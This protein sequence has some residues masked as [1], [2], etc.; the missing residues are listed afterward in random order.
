MFTLLHPDD[1]VYKATNNRS[2]VLKIEASGG[3]VLVTGDIEKK[4]ETRLLQ[5]KQELLSADI[6]IAPHHGSKSS[7]GVDF[8]D[9]QLMQDLQV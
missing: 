8:I 2:C 4:V 6:L 5:H 3:S 7:S 1:A 9:I